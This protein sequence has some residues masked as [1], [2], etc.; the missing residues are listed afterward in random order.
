[1]NRRGPLI[2]SLALV[3]LA[4][5]SCMLA[6]AQGPPEGGMGRRGR[7]PMMDANQLAEQ[8]NLT[9]DQKTKVDAILQDQRSQMMTLREDSSLSQD[10]RR[11]KMQTI[12]Q[13]GR[14]KIRALLNEEQRKKFD[15]MPQ[16]PGGRQ[17]QPP[18]NN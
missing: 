1:M 9:A 12:M 7:G 18:Q 11:T 17:S 16:G 2:A 15:A 5:F 14:T 4:L 8:L 10:E 6:A 3:A 13:S